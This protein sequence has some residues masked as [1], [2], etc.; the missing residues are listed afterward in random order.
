MLE[1]QYW[2]E[3]L[4]PALLRHSS[5]HDWLIWKHSDR[6]NAG[7]LDVSI[8]LEKISMWFELKIL[9]N[10][11]DSLQVNYLKKLGE[12]A[13]LISVA[14]DL[15]GA[16]IQGISFANRCR[17]PNHGGKKLTAEWIANEIAMRCVNV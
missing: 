16:V 5:L 12:G 7:I 17:F 10:E 15:H 13:Y 2:L 4:R 1:G 8:S 11:P 6:F 3:Y 9:P 14:K